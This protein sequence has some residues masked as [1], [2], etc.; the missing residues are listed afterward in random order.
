MIFKPVVLPVGM[1]T[2]FLGALLFIYLIIKGG[3]LNDFRN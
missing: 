1:L 3:N 2:A